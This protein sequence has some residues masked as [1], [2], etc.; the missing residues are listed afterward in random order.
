[1]F[2][3][4]R[5][6]FLSPFFFFVS[7][8][9]EFWDYAC[10]PDGVA[11]LAGLAVQEAQL[12]EGFAEDVFAGHFERVCWRLFRERVFRSRDYCDLTAW[13]DISMALLLVKSP[14]ERMVSKRS[15]AKSWLG[16]R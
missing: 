13:K 12:F 3:L 6:C 14:S 7:L 10:I 9:V 11:V 16:L 2:L 8:P 4:F 5:F 1:M 15:R